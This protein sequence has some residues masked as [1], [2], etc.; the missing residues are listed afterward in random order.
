M[1]T[2]AEKE[3]CF[4]VNRLLVV[5]FIWVGTLWELNIPADIFSCVGT[6]LWLWLPAMARLELRVLDY[7]RSK[8]ERMR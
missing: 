6:L 2:R 1:S 5:G 7:I 8:Y 3:R 4:T